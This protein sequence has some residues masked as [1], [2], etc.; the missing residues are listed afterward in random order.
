MNIFDLLN[1]ENLYSFEDYKKMF[2]HS[3]YKTLNVILANDI[4]QYNQ[5]KIYDANV[6][7]YQN[8][9]TIYDLY[10][11]LI[12]YNDEPLQNEEAWQLLECT[13]ITEDEFDTYRA[14]LKTIIPDS[15]KRQPVKENDISGIK[16]LKYIIGLFISCY[17][18]NK[19][20]VFSTGQGGKIV[21]S[22][23]IDGLSASYRTPDYLLEPSN[24]F[25]N[26]NPYGLEIL[27]LVDKFFTSKVVDIANLGFIN[28][29]YTI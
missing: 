21:A 17:I 23:S 11:S 8:R 9:Y 24:L 29:D 27:S 22:Q 26:S 4:Q 19:N 25:Y 16:M 7:V 18:A 14:L 20:N 2:S 12:K 13:L 28:S 15:A 5:D 10:K 3:L 1:N 6:I